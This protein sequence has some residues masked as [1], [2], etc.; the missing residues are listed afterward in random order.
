M[1]SFKNVDITGGFW[2]ERQKINRET[3][4]YSVYDRFKSTGR[5]STMD[6]SYK[7]GDPYKPHIYWGSDV[8]KWMEGAA[9]I[10]AKKED[11]KLHKLVNDVIDDVEKGVDENGYYNSYFN[12]IG[13]TEPK[14]ADRDKHELYSVGHMIEAA[15][16]LY[17][18]TGEDRLLKIAIKNTDYIDRVFRIEHSAKFITPGHEEIE[19][20]LI[21]LYDLLKEP[22]YLELAKFFVL[23]RGKTKEQEIFAN[24]GGVYSQSHTDVLHQTEAVG[25][26]VRAVYLYCAIADLAKRLNDE[27]LQK[28]AETLFDNIADKKMY[29]TG[30]IGAQIL[31]EAFSCGYDLPNRDAYAETCAAI[32]LAMFA[33]RLNNQNE[34]EPCSEYADVI[35]KAIYN[36]M[37]SGVSLSGDA[38]FYE[39]PLAVD[40]DALNI[41]RGHAYCT[42]RKKVFE[43]S[44][45]PPNITRIIASIGDYIYSQNKSRLFV[46][47]YIQN[48][49]EINGKK[50]E[51]TT[52][53]PKNGKIF[54]KTENKEIALRKPCWCKKVICS[55]KYTEKNGYLYFND[56]EIKIEFLMEPEFYY[57][58]NKVHADIFKTA[59]QYGPVVYCLEEQDQNESVFALKV[60]VNEKPKL[61][62]ETFGGLNIIKAF[63]EVVNYSENSLYT[64]QKPK[65]KNAVLKYIPY[66]S[67]ANRGEDNMTVWVNY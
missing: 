21:K 39:N 17:N 32:G 11:K 24:D 41:P 8:F 62:N 27:E 58:N 64:A 13:I 44:C 30:G 1:I 4:V 36:G 43:C 31:G 15:V 37:L 2:A 5:I 48:K 40:L 33:L 42:Q 50:V 55:Q 3:T 25:H 57:A 38:F 26:A 47:Q 7:E 49:A 34:E 12:S 9:Y 20:A 10:L 35:E 45:C 65:L 56:N 19:L 51:I 66:F 14:F 61:I 53:Y 6:C 67:F 18:A 63:G 54:I 59:L 16:A 22:K 52:E 60:N 23:Q 46:N 28:A 29:I